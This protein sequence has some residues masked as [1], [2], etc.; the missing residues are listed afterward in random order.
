M[1]EEFFKMSITKFMA[2]AALTSAFALAACGE[3]T[4]DADADGDGDVTA[5]EVEAL[6]TDL[7]P[8]AGKYSVN[9]N[10]V[11]ADIPGAPQQMLDAMGG[12]MNRS[13]EYCLSEEEAEKGF[14]ESLKE[15][16]SDSCQIDKFALTGNDIDMAMTCAA[17]GQG[18]MQ[19]SMTGTVSPTRSDISV[20][21][22]GTI[23]P[24]GD[25]NF[26]MTMLQE[27]I[28]DCDS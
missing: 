21:S 26:E 13:F 27:R 3:T 28:G 8:D 20:V 23:P 14:E 17:E 7:R 18:S 24:F 6:V 2:A 12:M 1:R 25:S 10:L 9:L 11:K 16:Q 5:A 19:V 4:V 22:K 15:G